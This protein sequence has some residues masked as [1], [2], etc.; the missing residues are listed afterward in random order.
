[1]VWQSY[2]QPFAAPHPGGPHPALAAFLGLFPGVGAMYNGQF[3]KGFIH[4][5]I[6]IVLFSIANHYDAF[7]FAVAVWIIYQSFEAF[8]TAKALRDGQ[9]PPDPLGLNE[10][11]YWLNP[12]SRPRPSVQPGVT[13]VQPIP[14]PPGQCAADSAIAAWQQSYTAQSQSPYPPPAAGSSVPPIPPIPPIPSC[15]WGRREPIGALVLIALGTL[16][17]LDQLDIFN[18][19]LFNYAWPVLLIALGVWLIVRRLTDSHGGSK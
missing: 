8:H 7:G 19:R 5:A 2:Q 9:P 16:F 15:C 12:N 4:A 13:P 10:V 6:F 17:L 3:V 11:G 14:G 18:G 1:M